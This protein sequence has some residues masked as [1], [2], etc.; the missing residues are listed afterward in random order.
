[1]AIIHQGRLTSVQSYWNGNTPIV[2]VQSSVRIRCVSKRWCSLI[3]DP[4]FAKCHFKRASERIQILLFSTRSHIRSQ[5]VDAP[6]GNK[7]K[8][9]IVPFKSYADVVRDKKK[10]RGR[11]VKIIGSCNGLVCV[12]L[13]DDKNFYI[14][15]P[16]TGDYRILHDLRISPLASKYGYGFGYNYST[17]DY[18]L[19]V[20]A[21]FIPGFNHENEISL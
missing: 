15:N 20:A 21:S 2:P 17:N 9:L 3:S 1:M 14:W 8:N 12:A 6:F 19:L 11:I 5:P 7:Y 16:S 18:N 4:Q 10:L 13:S